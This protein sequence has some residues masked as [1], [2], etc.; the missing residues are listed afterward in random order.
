[1]TMCGSICSDRDSG[2][3]MFKVTDHGCQLN[4]EKVSTVDDGAGEDAVQVYVEV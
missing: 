4:T 3:S 2:C 1:M